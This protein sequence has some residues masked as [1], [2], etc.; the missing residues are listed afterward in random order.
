MPPDQA[1]IKRHLQDEEAAK[2]ECEITNRML[3]RAQAALDDARAA[4]V[5]KE[6]KFRVA[7]LAARRDVAVEKARDACRVLE[8]KVIPAF[9]DLLRIDA[10]LN[11]LSF[12]KK[13]R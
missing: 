8:E 1:A 11:S 2:I 6:F 12:W 3:T 9:A 10:E 7:C 4:A 13:T 5:Q